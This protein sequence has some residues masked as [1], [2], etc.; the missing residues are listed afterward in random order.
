MEVRDIRNRNA[1]RMASDGLLGAALEMMA[2]LK[3]R[4][5]VIVDQLT[6][7]IGI[8]SD[9]DLAMYY[10][11]VNMTAEKWA[12]ATVKQIMTPDPVC[13]GS[14]ATLRTAAQLLLKS[15]VSALPVVDNGELV[16]ILSE[17]D[18]VRFS[19]GRDEAGGG[20]PAD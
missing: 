16:G 7:V 9:R 14:G 19:A 18:F 6:R 12:A 20:E 5:V 3:A 2:D 15:A 13:I 8:V 10:D 11:P 1:A 17:K 4:H